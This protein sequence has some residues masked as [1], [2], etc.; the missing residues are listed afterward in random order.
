VLTGDYLRKLYISKQ[1]ETQIVTWVA[2]DVDPLTVKEDAMALLMATWKKEAESLYP[3][4][5]DYRVRLLD[6]EGERIPIGSDIEFIVEEF[7]QPID[8]P[9][10][11]L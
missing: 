6:A 10:E 9:A 7:E 4:E 2:D 1:Y 8:P 11:E 5:G 3:G